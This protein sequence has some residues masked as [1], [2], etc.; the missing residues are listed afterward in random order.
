VDLIAC[1]RTC[2]WKK[3]KGSVGWKWWHFLETMFNTLTQYYICLIWELL[4]PFVLVNIRKRNL[5]WNHTQLKRKSSLSPK[6]FKLIIVISLF[7]LINLLW[8]WWSILFSLLGFA[9]YKINLLRC[10]YI[11]NFS[12][13]FCITFTTE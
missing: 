6:L 4:K 3:R 10:I 9:Q 11:F 12:L 1:M 8:W 7:I 5:N 13:S 2:N